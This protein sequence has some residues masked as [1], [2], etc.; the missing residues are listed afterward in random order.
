[1]ENK[2]L[3]D[4]EDYVA[5]VEPDFNF[6]GDGDIEKI[7]S[8]L[9]QNQYSNLIYV[10][11]SGVGKTANLYGIIQKKKRTIE[12]AVGPEE[13]RL[14][15]HMIDRRFLLL[16]T[17]D[18]ETHAGAYCTARQAWLDRELFLSS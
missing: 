3:I 6:V 5:Q 15:L 10:G 8:I 4:L 11:R 9:G 18:P 2:L 7:S 14:P 13:K 1:M 17:K 12:G 16:D